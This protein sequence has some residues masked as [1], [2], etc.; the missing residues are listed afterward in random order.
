MLTV[1][2]ALA[3]NL[4]AILGVVLARGPAESAAPSPSRMATAALLTAAL[5]TGLLCLALTPLVWRMR[6]VKPPLPIVL[7]AVLVGMAPIVTLVVLW[8]FFA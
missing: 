6:P 2:S 8:L 5:V 4:A 7:I 3:A 1:F